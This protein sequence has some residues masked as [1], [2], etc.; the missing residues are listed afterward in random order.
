MQADPP[1]AML[2]SQ[3]HC[4]PAGVP[5]SAD[6]VLHTSFLSIATWLNARHKDPSAPTPEG[7]QDMEMDPPAAVVLSEA[8]GG[9]A[10]NSPDEQAAQ[11]KII[12][13]VMQ[14]LSF[15]SRAEVR[16][17]MQLHNAHAYHIH[18]AWH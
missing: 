1:A 18:A 7:A 13:K 16:F 12:K 11:A 8:G 14:E 3:F 15:H 17:S 10:G 5:V 4:M 9:A 2:G 6:I